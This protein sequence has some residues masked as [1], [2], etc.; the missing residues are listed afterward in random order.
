[1]K[2]QKKAA[3]PKSRRKKRLSESHSDL[4]TDEEF[5]KKKKNMMSRRVPPV[6]PPRNPDT[7]ARQEGTEEGIAYVEW[8]HSQ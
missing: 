8:L 2:T 3:I 6:N 4:S 1:M 5:V 7:V